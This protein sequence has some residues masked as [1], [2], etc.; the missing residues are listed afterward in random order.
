MV[1]HSEEDDEPAV[2]EDKEEEEDEEEEA[3]A[4][5]SSSAEQPTSGTRLAPAISRIIRRR[6]RTGR[7]WASPPSCS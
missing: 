6:A 7:S 5:E 1:A 2:A 3:D 4:A